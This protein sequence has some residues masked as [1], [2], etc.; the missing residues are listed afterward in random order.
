[1]KN[2]VAPHVTQSLYW[3]TI[4]INF[5]SFT[6]EIDICRPCEIHDHVC[7]LIFVDNMMNDPRIDSDICSSIFNSIMCMICS[8]AINPAMLFNEE[9]WTSVPLVSV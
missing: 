1:M 6:I 2:R 8:D 7:H 3:K 4:V 5:N 9:T